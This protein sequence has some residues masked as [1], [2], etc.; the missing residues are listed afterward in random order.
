MHPCR[1]SVAAAL[2]LLVAT[3]A[4][5]QTETGRVTGIVFDPQG[6]V[7]PGATI[8]LT[9]TA[10][11]AVRT[12]ISDGS[13][14][15]VFANVP[16]GPYT[17][18]VELSGFATQ[19]QDV[20]VTVGGALDVNNRLQLAATAEAVTVVAESSFVNLSNPEVATTI[21]QDQIRDLPTLTRNVYDLVAIAGNVVASPETTIDVDTRGAGFNVNG[22][23]SAGNN[24]LL[25][26]AANNDEFTADVGQEV[27]LD[28]IQE[29]A[30]VTNNFSAQYGRASGG[31]INAIT[32]SG[33]NRFSGSAYEYFRSEKLATNT[34][35]NRANDIEKGKFS[36]HQP[37][38]SLG[39]PIVRDKLFFFSS[40]EGIR[41]RSFDT[42]FSWVPTPEFIGAMAP[43]ART[44][45][46][47]Y[48]KGAQINGPI[49]TRADVSAI[50][51]SGA[52]A[53]NSLPANLPVF[54]RVA[55]SLPID[56]G[57]GDPQNNYQFV[58]RVDWNAAGNTNA[59]FRYAY[60]NQKK[61]PGT[62][63]S[64]P[65]AGYDT[66]ETNNNHNLLGSFTR[67]FSSTLTAQSK[68]VYNRLR[69]EQPLN[70]PNVPTLFMN[71]GAAV[72]LQG[73]RIAFPGYGPWS[74]GNAIPFGGPQAFTQFYQDQT[75]LRGAHDIRFGGS[76]VHMND[77]RTFGAYANST[78]FLNTTANALISL[79]NL[80][81]G[82]LAR[83]Q[84]AINPHG[85]PGGA[86]VT[87]VEL[88][89]FTSHNKYNEFALYAQ[90]NWNM[91]DRLT[92]NLGVRYEYFGPQKKSEPKFD[93][94]FYYA[95][96]NASVNTSAPRDIIAAV[97]GGDV[98]AS[99]KS[100]TGTL[101]KPDKNNFAPRFGFA[102][103]L[104]GDGR[105]SFRGG[106][107]ISYERNFGNVTFNVLF[108]PPEYL[109][110]TIDAPQDVP[111]APIVTDLAGPFGG[112]AGVR[113][114]IPAGSLRHVDQNIETA[115]VHQYGLSLQRQL[116]RTIA[117]S[118][119]YNGSSGRNLYDL[120]DVNKRG[121][122]LVYEGVGT[123]TSRPNPSFGAFNTRGNRGRSQYHGV[124]FGFDAREFGATGLGLTSKYTLSKA[125][126]NLSTTFSEGIN[127]FT[128]NLG[129]LDPF[130]C[131]SE[132]C[133]PMLDWGYAEFDVRHRYSMS[134]IWNIPFLRDATGV[135]G[136]LLGGWSV[137][138]ILTA[139]SG[140]PFS[141]YDCTNGLAVCMRALAPGNFSRNTGKGTATGN[142]N[143]FVLLDY[144][145]ILPLAGTYVHP[146]TRNNDFG[147]YPSNMTR[148]DA[149]R[150]PGA[151]FVDM[152][153]QKRF[154]V[155]GTKSAAFRLEIYNLFDHANMYVLGET[156]DVSSF[157]AL[158][159]RRGAP[160]DPGDTNDNRRAQ[161]A[162]RFDF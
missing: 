97:R 62:V 134:T 149:F 116:T 48:G 24:I 74:P 22:A 49:L 76:Y 55:K 143:E 96:P 129:Y 67:V 142:P 88:P 126:D 108:N 73:Q 68:L 42:Q 54:G 58:E 113:K 84:T 40:F 87:P 32:K 122:P 160:G 66:G 133:G 45:F 89:S 138:W 114:T 127:S 57:G 131:D 56:A 161:V 69:N 128:G 28:S 83:F 155:G 70:G 100:P 158:T 80:A 137:N 118:I 30:V 37:G 115:Y 36:R 2:I 20:T 78:E 112:V 25:D 132:N 41:V 46:E 102:Y 72:R 59:Y 27:P 123:A 86:Y 117:G 98:L 75:W 103:D 7:V 120:A 19:R 60:Q 16:P 95:D 154:R 136:S 99:N 106:Y 50:V 9:S 23:R 150:G 156:V 157:G 124:T 53:F 1:S 34:P 29:F 135:K 51:G 61:Q 8:T 44:F 14:R 121:A 159:G 81:L 17:L 119:E 101:W 4:A 111:V 35:D 147:P 125:H 94:N 15:Y 141:L 93:S 151:W 65:Y 104:T 105:T 3:L 33:A 144:A 38:Y 18:M 6:A 21:R 63:V 11:G 82:Q 77:D 91:T 12:T 148:R 145:P 10:N 109:V 110:A 47:T 52:G 146:L 71:T 43:A 162:F 13:G 130:N 39:G 153:L 64:S 140:Y 85:F 31:I 79:N 139:R 5:A 107:G 26:G 90:D 92:V 152:A